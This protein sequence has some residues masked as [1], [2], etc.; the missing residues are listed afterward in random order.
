MRAENRSRIDGRTVWSIFAFVIF[1]V[2]KFVW[3]KTGY[4]E[5]ITFTS[6]LQMFGVS[7]EEEVYLF[8]CLDKR[9]YIEL[10]LQDIQKRH[11]KEHKRGRETSD[12]NNRFR[13]PHDSRESCLLLQQNSNECC[14]KIRQTNKK[15]WFSREN[16]EHCC[17]LDQTSKKYLHKRYNW[18]YTSWDFWI[19]LKEKDFLYNIYVYLQSCNKIKFSLSLFRNNF[20]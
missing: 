19:Y 7:Q 2:C 10:Y 12:T 17:D 9:Q 13:T 6:D 1:N 11:T 8:D 20:L 5:T 4:C 3:K 16:E 18:F 15:S 14:R